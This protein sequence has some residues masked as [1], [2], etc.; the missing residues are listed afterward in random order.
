M[1]EDAVA[2]ASTILPSFADVQK[3]PTSQRP[4]ALRS[5][6]RALTGQ[7]ISALLSDAARLQ[8]HIRAG[9]QQQEEQ[10]GLLAAVVRCAPE[11]PGFCNVSLAELLLHPLG[12]HPESGLDCPLGMLLLSSPSADEAVAAY[13]WSG[14]DI[15]CKLFEW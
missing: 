9:G 4:R 11:L 10:R 5:L 15:L 7:E 14:G 13:F 2:A 12:R 1:K 6:L 8:L 3:L